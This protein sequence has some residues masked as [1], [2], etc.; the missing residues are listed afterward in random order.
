MPNIGRELDDGVTA[1]GADDATAGVDR[2]AMPEA[3]DVCGMTGALTSAFADLG[4]SGRGGGSFSH[5]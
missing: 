5:R 1:V 2:D 3:S 4:L